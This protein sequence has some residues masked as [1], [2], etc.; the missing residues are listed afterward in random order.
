[1]ILLNEGVSHEI[2]I[3]FSIRNSY[4]WNNIPYRDMDRDNKIKYIYKIRIIR[5]F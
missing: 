3:I 4:I 1:M 5:F 2:K